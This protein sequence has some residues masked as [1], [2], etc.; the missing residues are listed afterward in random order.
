MGNPLGGEMESPVTKLAD[1]VLDV[2]ESNLV[3]RFSKE[4]YKDIYD[5]HAAWVDYKARKKGAFEIF[6]GKLQEVTMDLWGIAHALDLD[7]MLFSKLQEAVSKQIPQPPPSTYSRV[8]L[9]LSSARAAAQEMAKDARGLDA[10][11]SADLP[12]FGGNLIGVLDALS[13]LA[14]TLKLEYQTFDK[15][16]KMLEDY[17]EGV[18]EELVN[19][20][21]EGAVTEVPF[22]SIRLARRVVARFKAAR[23]A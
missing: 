23:G 9:A 1:D 10:G 14:K 2:G 19:V 18:S 13:T 5:A 6:Q 22:E 7:R 16:R 21:A 3:E 11:L 12:M 8:T 20:P 15:A 4:L 17:F